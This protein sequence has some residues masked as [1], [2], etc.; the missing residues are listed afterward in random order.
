MAGLGVGRQRPGSYGV[1]S[2]TGGNLVRHQVIHSVPPNFMLLA[3]FINICVISLPTD[4][5][6]QHISVYNEDLEP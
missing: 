1:S 4:N 5:F 6:T 3:T 2:S